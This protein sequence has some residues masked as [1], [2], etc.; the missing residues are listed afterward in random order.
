MPSDGAMPGARGAESTV[1]T[2][3][4]RQHHHQFAFPTSPVHS[5]SLASPAAVRSSAAIS[6]AAAASAPPP[7]LPVD[8][9]D[10][11]R[12]RVLLSLPNAPNFAYSET[13][14]GAAAREQLR[15]FDCDRCKAFYEELV[16]NPVAKLAA[17]L[18][19]RGMSAEQ[20][21]LSDKLTA[22]VASAQ[23]GG[24]SIADA[25]SGFCPEHRPAGVGTLAA[26]TAAGS[27]PTRRA[28]SAAVAAAAATPAMSL[29]VPLAPHSTAIPSAII[30]AA[31]P[32]RR[33][34]AIPAAGAAPAAA[35]VL[36]RQASTAAP[37][38]K[39]LSS[40]HRGVHSPPRT[41]PWYWAV[42]TDDFKLDDDEGNEG[43]GR[44]R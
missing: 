40:R 35:A 11:L 27:S 8:E 20:L 42:E 34:S 6:S 37:S 2:A 5:A 32:A 39:T 7:R 10:E 22:A 13:V 23:R 9:E 43:A 44:G 12:R 16:G 38:L 19:A 18:Q 30:T 25:F 15:G 3:P 14:R 21:N 26:A 31:A 28:S 1:S 41:P 4:I 33:A 24:T 36:A 17:E 29:P